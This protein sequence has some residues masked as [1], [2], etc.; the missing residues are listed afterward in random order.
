M[1][2]SIDTCQNNVS[3][4]QYHV[5]ISLAQV[6]PYRGQLFFFLKLTTDQGLAV[7]WIAGSSK[8]RHSHLSI[9]EA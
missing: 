9:N 1:F 4:D 7:D 6:G 8:V 3:A 5:T 2:W